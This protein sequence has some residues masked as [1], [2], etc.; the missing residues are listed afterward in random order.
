MDY[1]SPFEVASGCDVVE[2]R[3]KYPDLLI[4]GWFDKRILAVS[5]EEIDREIDRIIPF[6]KEQGGYI[7]SCDHAVP[8]EVTFEN[9]Y[10]FRKKMMEYCK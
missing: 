3:K 7:P 10:H 9:Y 6:M 4:R 5:K 1:M 8:E 2:V